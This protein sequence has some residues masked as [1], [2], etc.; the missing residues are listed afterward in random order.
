MVAKS[1]IHKKAKPKKKQGARSLLIRKKKMIEALTASLGI[2]TTA[3][4]NVGIARK[5]HYQWY[6]T[7]TKYKESVDD[8]ADIAI[9]FAESMLH[10]QIKDQDT[11]ATIFYLKT[12]GKKRGYVERTELTGEGGKDLITSLQIEIINSASQ[13]KKDDSGS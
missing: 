3:C 9:D 12:K 4:K 1:N 13:V 8:I 10:K 5:T 7:D 11:T 6:K 2:V